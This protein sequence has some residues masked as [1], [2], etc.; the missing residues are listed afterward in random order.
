MLERS[1]ALK[2]WA[3]DAPIVPGRD[4]PARRLDDHRTAYL[5]YEG[6]VS[7]GRGT[8]RRLDRGTYVT[9]EWDETSIRVVI[10]GAQLEGEVLIRRV[11][12]AC[13]PETLWTL[14]LGNFD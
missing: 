12:S 4:L 9:Q 7:R 2:T 1:G 8:V 6:P 5:D 3:V 14:R 13:S 10:Q 11:A